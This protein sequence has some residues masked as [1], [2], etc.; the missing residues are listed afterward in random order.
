MLNKN[1]FDDTLNSLETIANHYKT[2]CY[3]DK[4]N[5]LKSYKEEFEM[6]LIVVGGFNA[7]KSALLNSLIGRPQFLKESQNPET[8]IATELR[9]S[10]EE[11]S[12]VKREN[13]T[14]EKLSPNEEYNSKN[15]QLIQHYISSPNLEKI[16]DFIIVDTPGFNSGI[17][18]HN[19]ALSQYVGVGSAY[20]FVIDSENGSINKSN[21][22][23]LHEISSY[24][25]RIAV[26][27][28]KW[29]MVTP[30]NKED[31]IESFKNKLESNGYDYPVYT[32]SREEPLI[33]NKLID[34]ISCFQPQEIFNERMKFAFTECISSFVSSLTMTN[35]TLYLD[36]YSFDTEISKYKKAQEKLNTSFMQKE[37]DLQRLLPT[38]LDNV[39]DNIKEEL[40][41]KSTTIVEILKMGN[42]SGV[43]AV[44]M[45]TVR[46]VIMYQLQ[47]IN[48]HSIDSISS[49][50][51]FTGVLSIDESGNIVESVTQLA[52]HL[53]FLMEEGSF[54]NKS[55][56]SVQKE[57]DNK[58][59]Y[60][61]V[62]GVGAAI[63]TVLAPWAEVLIILA[64]DI[65]KL[66]SNLFGE[67]EDE[68]LK[69]RFE[70]V[71]IP[72]VC[73]SL[74]RPITDAIN[75]NIITI[76]DEF[77]RNI[78]AQIDTIQENLERAENAK[79]QS[80]EDFNLFQNQIQKDIDL[81]KK[82]EIELGV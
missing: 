24:S 27:I 12:F 79:A 55:L 1:S 19:Q 48:V 40:Y 75:N 20:L 38:Q 33:E 22:N 4:I 31:I 23:Y 11:K 57:N 54:G 45:E 41:E 50:L 49:N 81:L 18:A 80:Q 82:L 21:L 56:A 67:S 69:K 64:P 36:T 66:C 58:N 32:I 72:Q 76:L 77:K 73:Q 37:K 68:K 60:R 29:G 26:L 47:E 16:S 3:Y 30:S 63:S 7:G 2:E 43:E 65:I 9:F 71:I 8:A 15:C 10:K 25:T 13:G 70:S 17:E 51:D 74:Q 62:T 34:I 5:E 59:L 52:N 28:S 42:Q 39:L 44:I 78:Q 6:K 14:F 35:R 46:P 61:I 53:K